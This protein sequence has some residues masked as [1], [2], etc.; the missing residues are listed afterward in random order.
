MGAVGTIFGNKKGWGMIRLI[1]NFIMKWGWDFNRD[2]R[3][4]NMPADTVRGSKVSRLLRSSEDVDSE[5][6]L[7]ITV[8]NALGGKIIT[9]RHY[10]HKTDRHT[11]RLY[12]VPDEMDFERELG[13]MITMESMRG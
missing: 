12:V 9:F 1:W 13:K 11:H 10:D 2:L 6:G 7:N 4:G 5:Q 8:R 3:D